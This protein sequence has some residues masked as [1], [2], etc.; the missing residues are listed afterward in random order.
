MKDG[1][2]Y[3]VIILLENA[4]ILVVGPYTNKRLAHE[5]AERIWL[6]EPHAISFEVEPI[7]HPGYYTPPKKEEGA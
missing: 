1:K 4:N 7:V 5:D 2:G 6:S 3:C